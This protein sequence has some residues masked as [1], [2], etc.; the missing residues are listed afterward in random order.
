M[1]N[2]ARV[3]I[4]AAAPLLRPGLTISATCSW[5]YAEDT[6]ARIM[7]AVRAINAPA[8]RAPPM[9]APDD[10]AL[11]ERL[12]CIATTDH[13]RGCEGRNYACSCGWDE[14]NMEL[15]NAAAARIEALA[16][17]VE[18]LNELVA[19]YQGLALTETICAARALS[20]PADE[21]APPQEGE[22]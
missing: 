17:E 22:P 21:P 12:R 16:A 14:E 8:P 6:T 13:E 15:G 18:R 3:T 10:A 2:N 5:R 11:C 4:T 9:T 1:T 7:D 20:R 19:E